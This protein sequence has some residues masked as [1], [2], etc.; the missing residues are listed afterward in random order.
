[1][2]VN[3]H[4][5]LIL[6]IKVLPFLRGHK[7]TNIIEMFVRMLCVHC[8]QNNSYE[9]IMNGYQARKIDEMRN[10][11]LDLQLR[12]TSVLRSKLGCSVS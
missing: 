6:Y 4:S 3:Y 10:V 7:E 9:I 8:D 1:M 2:V 12:E 11:I 5:P